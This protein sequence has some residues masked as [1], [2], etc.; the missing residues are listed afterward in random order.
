MP[1]TSNIPQDDVGN[2][3]DSQAVRPAYSSLASLP[4]PVELHFAKVLARRP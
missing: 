1:Y 4:R 3:S 2:Q